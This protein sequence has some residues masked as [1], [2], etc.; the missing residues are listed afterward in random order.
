MYPRSGSLA[1]GCVAALASARAVTGNHTESSD[2]APG[3][4][5]TAIALNPSHALARRALGLVLRDQGDYGAAVEELRRS[6]DALPG[7]A[8]A[9]H[10]LGHKADSDA[11]LASLIGRFGT[12]SPIK[13]ASV[14]AFRGDVD[15]AF[16]WLDKA[17][18]ANDTA[19]LFLAMP[20][21]FT[22]SSFA[23]HDHLLI[24]FVVATA[25]IFHSFARDWESGVRSWRKLFLASVLLGLAT[26]TKY[27]GIFLGLGLAVWILW[28]PR[29][30][31]LYLTPQLWLAAL[32]AVL[33]QAPVI[34]VLVYQAS[35]GTK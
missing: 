22:M 17:K 18:A 3:S 19:V 23:Y 4:L 14:L 6:A 34:G 9:H 2:P 27:N 15:R 5:R 26:L 7:D 35:G 29:L 21:I 20:I 28:R 11:A 30:R 31:G 8:M 33:I 24:F 32:L 16:E 12:D 13:V 1:R 25:Y 10:L